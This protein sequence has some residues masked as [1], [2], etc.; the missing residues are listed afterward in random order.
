MKTLGLMFPWLA[1]GAAG[2]FLAGLLFT[3]PGTAEGEM[4]IHDFGGLPVQDN[5]AASRWTRMPE[6]S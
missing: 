5:G 2:L 6:P 4:N 1:V 3:P